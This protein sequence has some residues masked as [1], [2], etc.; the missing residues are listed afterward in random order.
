MSKI[1]WIGNRLSDIE[2]CLNFFDGSINLYG[3][4]YKEHVSFYE[5]R[6]NNNIS[7]PSFDKF[8]EKHINDLLINDGDAKF[9][10]YNPRRAYSYSSL[11]K[12]H[13]V[14]STTI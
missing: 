10:F 8:I 14:I 4:G 3:D 11:I 9:M 13:T 5:Y 7:N 12:Q 2:T 6:A 1:I